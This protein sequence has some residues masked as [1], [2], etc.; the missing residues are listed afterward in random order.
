MG[1]YFGWGVP[2]SVIAAVQPMDIYENACNLLNN[3]V[4]EKN[5]ALSNQVPSRCEASMMGHQSG[6]GYYH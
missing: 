4:I 1:Q 3:W 2:V 5:K 6:G